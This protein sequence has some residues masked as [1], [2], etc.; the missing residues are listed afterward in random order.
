MKKFLLITFIFI[1]LGLSKD[2]NS[3]I[4]IIDQSGGGDFTTIQ[5]GIIASSHGDTVLAYPGRYYE[6][7]NFNGKN[8]TLAS[9]E[10]ITGDETYIATTIIDGNEQGSCVILESNEFEAVIRGFS[11]TNGSGDIIYGDIDRLGG[12]IRISTTFQTDPINASIVNC[13]IF[14]NDAVY[15]GGIDVDNADITLSGVSI[16]NNYASSGGGLSI[17]DESIITFD[18][19]NLCNI[20]NNFAGQALDILAS[21]AVNDIHVIVDTFTVQDQ[22]D[23][24]AYY[25]RSITST[26][27]ITIE[28]QNH[29]LERINHNLYISSDGNNDNSGLTP[30]T[31]MKTIA[32]ALQK[33]ESDSIIP[34]TIYVA[35]GT[36]SQELNDQIFPLSAKK[37]VSLIGEDMNTTLINNDYSISTY[38]M[39]HDKG[40]N[41]LENFTFSNIDQS[42]KYPIHS[43]HSNNI[44]VKNIIIEN[45]YVRHGSIYFYR[46]YEISFNNIV[47]QNNNSEGCSGLWLDGGNYTIKNS[48]FDNNDSI[49][50]DQFISNFY[51]FVDDYLELENCIFSNSDIPPFPY[52]EY[53]TI[54]IAAQQNCFPDIKISDCLFTNNSTLNGNYIAFISSP[55]SVEV[56][57]CTFTQNTS[58]VCPLGIFGEIDF[59][60]NIL[61]NNESNYEYEIN[62]GNWP[63]ITSI[64]NV[65]YCDIEGGESAIYPGNPP[66]QATINWLEG[67]IDDDPIFLLSGDNPYQLTLESPCVDTGT[68]DITGYFLPPWDLLHN[69]RVW[70]GDGNGVAIIDMG[71]YEYDAPPVGVVNY[72]LPITNYNL[73]NYPNPFNPTTTISFNIDNESEVIITVY[74]IKGQKVKQLVSDHISAGQ[75]SI[76][77]NGKDSNN[78]S[79]ASGI[80]FYKLMIG[81]YSK[82]KKMILLK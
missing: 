15:G 43:A 7:V 16:Y 14:N 30:D 76:V 77:W 65:E 80:Y 17:V 81:D 74:N 35:A 29:F 8:I 68:P 25:Q 3:T 55:G 51:C 37:Y 75:H 36:Y 26:G 9:L 49:G 63:T 73:H 11:I 21:D 82:T 23:Y 72:E 78:K 41:S 64:L 48:I 4:W 22:F 61:Y 5:E 6:N 46:C 50:P 52:E 53:Y 34:K 27:V 45:C 38:I 20:Y 44:N 60:N 12:G 57:N 2:L 24:F 71:C 31:P 62:T 70:D 79:V 39:R 33:I 10:L 54:Q 19:D 32:L 28:L 56:N 66:N 42:F 59:R 18:S 47:V 58:H 1:F 40:F 67:N 13:N 69:E